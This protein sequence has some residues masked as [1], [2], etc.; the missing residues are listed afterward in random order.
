[1]SK[2]GYT[3]DNLLS[4]ELVTADGHV[5]RV[6]E[7]ENPE[8]FWG[9]RGGGGNFGIATGFEFALHELGPDVH[10]GLI[11]FDFDDAAKSLRL[12]RESADRDGHGPL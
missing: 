5:V 9:L 2:Y 10:G 6:S 3:I 7:D 12:L 8:L 11:A 4:V 1:M